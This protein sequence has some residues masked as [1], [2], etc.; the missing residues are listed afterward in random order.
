MTSKQKPS[1]DELEEVFASI[2]PTQMQIARDLLTQ[3]GIECF[4]FDT[5]SSRMLGTTAAIPSRLMVH[6]HAARDALE[7]LKEL[8]FED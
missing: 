8:G 6:A 2:D 7:R 5:E 4:V 3:A 1:P